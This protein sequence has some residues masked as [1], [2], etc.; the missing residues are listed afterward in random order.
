M[1]PTTRPSLVRRRR[2]AWSRAEGPPR[3]LWDALA[4][5]SYATLGLVLGGVLIWLLGGEA[6]RLREVSVY[7]SQV[8]P[9]AEV[10]ARLD[11]QGRHPL[12]LRQADLEG[13]LAALP[14]LRAAQV[15]VFAPGTVEVTVTER[16]PVLTWVAGDRRWL[17]DEQGLVLRPAV[18]DWPALPVVYQGDDRTPVR[19]QQLNPWVL[20][21]ALRLAPFVATSF[22]P[23][24]RLTYY[25]EEGLVVVAPRWRALFD[26][27]GDLARQHAALR[28]LQARGDDGGRGGTV[29]DVRFPDRGYIRPAADSPPLA[30][31]PG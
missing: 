9:A 30:G 14:E 26:A 17:V 28:A 23:T 31:R 2:A 12:W 11:V 24:A 1:R 29:Y 22:E 7:G 5:L 8:L 19:G 21:N 4:R 18:S 25:E 16:Q 20:G 13:R 15:E 10:V 6:L 27:G 3:S